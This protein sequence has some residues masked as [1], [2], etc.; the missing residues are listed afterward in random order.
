MS[1]Y[2]IGVCSYLAIGKNVNVSG[3]LY[4]VFCHME[5]TIL[6]FDNIITVHVHV[7]GHA[8][9]LNRMYMYSEELPDQNLPYCNNSSF[10]LD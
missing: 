1:I 3:P 9:V 8:F 6:V 2:M 5:G 4:H 10:L 7:G